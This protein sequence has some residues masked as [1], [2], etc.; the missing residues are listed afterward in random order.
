MS[1]E[2]N[3][4]R[5]DLSV[6]RVLHS[7][8][9]PGNPNPFLEVIDLFISDSPERILKIEDAIRQQNARGLDAEA[10]TLKGSASS[11]GAG[12]LAQICSTLVHCARKSEFSQTFGLLEPLRAEFDRVRVILEAEK[13]KFK[14]SSTG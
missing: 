11:L 4:G 14:R 10:H 3:P 8:A 5:V 6:L 7:L 12:P 9:T 2:P 13:A 1:P